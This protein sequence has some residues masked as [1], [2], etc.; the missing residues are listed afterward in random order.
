MHSN[1]SRTR[2]WRELYHKEQNFK[3][4]H[5]TKEIPNLYK[6]NFKDNSESE[7]WPLYLQPWFGHP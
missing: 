6:R 7:I 4:K 3:H 1:I 2:Q 5:S